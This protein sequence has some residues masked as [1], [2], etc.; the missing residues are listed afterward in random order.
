MVDAYLP[1]FGIS[2]NPN[3]YGNEPS[4]IEFD[5]CPVTIDT[6]KSR[7]EKG[8]YVWR[9]LAIS[10]TERVDVNLSFY[11][12]GSAQII[13]SPANRTSMTYSGKLTYIAVKAE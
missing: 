11:G 6:S 7:P 9:F 10:G 3:V 4:G 2:Y 13:C 1:F 5:D 12:N 8:K